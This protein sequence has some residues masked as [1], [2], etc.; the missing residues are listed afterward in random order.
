MRA[1]VNDAIEAEVDGRWTAAFSLHESALTVAGTADER[2]LA[3][4]T[5]TR[6]L[7]NPDTPPLPS[8]S[9]NGLEAWG[10]AT[11]SA[12]RPWALRALTA[13]YSAADDLATARARA[14]TLVS[15][16]GA[17]EHAQWGLM[18]EVELALRA[19]DD[20][21]ALAALAALESGWP[22]AAGTAAALALVDAALGTAAIAS[23][24]LGDGAVVALTSLAADAYA[25]GIGT[26]GLL[27]PYPN[28][29]SGVVTVPIVLGEATDLRVVVFDVLGREVAHLA[30]GRFEA[31]VHHIRFD[32]TRL[33]AGAYVVRATGGR[34]SDTARLTLTR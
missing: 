25:E 17:T 31:G 7:G 33:P 9:L 3:F 1:F 27:A 20:A 12:K 23:A 13:A 28:P 24:G 22:N 19:G 5:V 30:E 15:D 32:G 2:R 16:F 18:A 8:G 4:G 14:G 11:G 29:S 34:L 21:A 26:P 6:L 10:N